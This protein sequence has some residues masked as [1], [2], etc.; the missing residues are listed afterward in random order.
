MKKNLAI[1]KGFSLFE[2][3]VSVVILFLALTP[4]FASFFSQKDFS[5]LTLKEIQAAC[6]AEEVTSQ[7][8]VYPVAFIKAGNFAANT[9]LNAAAPPVNEIYGSRLFGPDSP[10]L[11]FTSMDE[12]FQRNIKIKYDPTLKL[13]NIE[14]AITFDTVTAAGKPVQRTITNHA[15]IAAFK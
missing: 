14:V 9:P 1:I 8:Y 11:Y 5:V 6:Y 7:L 2:V 12:G 13:N 10:P 4:L 15:I 3:I